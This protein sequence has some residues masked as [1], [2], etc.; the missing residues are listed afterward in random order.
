MPKLSEI[1]DRSRQ[2]WDE[3]ALRELR[4]FRDEYEFSKTFYIRFIVGVNAGGIIAVLSFIGTAKTLG[5]NPLFSILCLLCFVLGLA[6]AGLRL[7]KLILQ[8]GTRVSNL[9][10]LYGKIQNDKANVG[11]FFEEVGSPPAGRSPW[12]SLAFWLALIG[13]LLG[14]FS[15]I[16]ITATME[17]AARETAS[18]PAAPPKTA[19]TIPAPETTP[20][21]EN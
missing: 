17:R 15:V 10:V 2:R 1:N 14:I 20:E 12:A 19:T 21:S 6:C 8:E 3:A 16:P 9:A 7:R 5:P 13:L 11:D 18:T 4:I